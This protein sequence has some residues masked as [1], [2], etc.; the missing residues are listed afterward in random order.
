MRDKNLMELIDNQPDMSA[1]RFIYEGMDWS[2]VRSTDHSKWIAK[3]NT[4]PA[5]YYVYEEDENLWASVFGYPELPGKPN[6]PLGKFP[7]KA[8]AMTACERH[9]YHFWA[10]SNERAGTTSIFMGS[11]D[12]VSDFVDTLS[13]QEKDDL[14]DM[15]S[16][17]Y[18]LPDGSSFM[19]MASFFPAEKSGLKQERNGSYSATLKIEAQDLPLWLIHSQPGSKLV[20]GATLLESGSASDW[21]DRAKRALKRSFAL[22]I[23][24]SFQIWLAKKYDRWGLIATALT[25]NS[26]EVE[27]AVA[28]TLRRLMGCP[29]RR[30]LATNR[31][32]IMKIERIDREF[33]LDM[34]RGFDTSYQ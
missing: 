15:L 25:K 11:P 27:N 17:N 29:T 9:D 21:E 2:L 26:E 8:I 28:E 10:S 6:V 5:T 31:D 4:T 34:S 3:S 16:G 33:Y 18:A 12:H 19:T 13:A 20:I 24:N 23:E 7:S 1:E 22:C 32:A 14:L 30:D